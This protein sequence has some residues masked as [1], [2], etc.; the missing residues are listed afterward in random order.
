MAFELR[1]EPIESWP[2]ES[3][4]W[5]SSIAF[6]A[7]HGRTMTLLRRELAQLEAKGLVVLQVVT[8]N[9][10]DDLRRDGELRAGTRVEHPGC[11][12]SFESRFGSLTYATDQFASQSV[13][14]F[15][16]WEANLRAITLSLE[17]LR[18]VDRYGVSK[19]GEQYR[20]WLALTAATGSGMSEEIARR[21]LREQSGMDGQFAPLDDQWRQARKRV[22]PDKHNNDRTLWDSVEEARIVLGLE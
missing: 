21:V 22:H 7:P 14:S 1:T 9:G 18:A 15:V 8:R 10:A 17:A 3:T 12:L 13:N 4:R 5:R 11:R 20:G 2:Y 16:S 6:K 19:S